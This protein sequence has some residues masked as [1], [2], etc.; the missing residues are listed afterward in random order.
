MLES[1]I[2]YY[3]F[4]VPGELISGQSDF[5]AASGLRP[6]ERERVKVQTEYGKNRTLRKRG[7]R[8]EVESGGKRETK[9][10]EN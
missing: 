8:I 4:H 6:C 3:K 9:K 1:F 10:M 7:Q 2:F 5:G